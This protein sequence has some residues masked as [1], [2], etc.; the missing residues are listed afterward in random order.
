MALISMEYEQT[1]YHKHV[2]ISLF[3]P[4]K[5]QAMMGGHGLGGA[6]GFIKAD[7]PHSHIKGNSVCVCCLASMPCVC[8]GEH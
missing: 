4:N 2:I 8:W 7:S 5:V 1:L 6:C 3:S